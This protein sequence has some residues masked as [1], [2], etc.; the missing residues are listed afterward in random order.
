VNWPKRV[1]HRKKVLATIYRKSRSYPFYR[2]V[3]HVDGARRMKAFANYSGE[4]GAKQWADELVKGLFKG[5]KVAALTPRQAS[6]ALTAF[7]RLQRHFLATGKRV[8]LLASVSEYCEESAKANGY[9]LGAMVDGFLSTVAAVN[10][11]DIEK[12]AEQF[13]E[14][15]KRRTVTKDGRRPQLSPEHHYNTSLWL[16]E[17]GKAF[18]GHAVCDL[19]KDFLNK[20]IATHADAAPKTRNER[21][22]MVKMFLKWCVEKDYLSRTHRL[23]EASDLKH[24]IADPEEIECYTAAE[25]RKMLERA[26]KPPGPPKKG[27][28]PERDFQDLTP[29][30]AL[31]GL[32]GIREK[33]IMRLTFEDLFRVPDHVEVKAFK[34][35]TRSRRL[36]QSCAALVAW[37]EPYRGQTGPV[38]PKGYDMFHEDFA[39]L[40][41]ELK[42][43]ARRNGLRHSFVSAHFAAYSDEGLTAAQ[44][45]NSPAMVHKNY[46]GL[47]TKKEGEAWFAVKP[48]T[49]AQ[50][51]IRLKITADQN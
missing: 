24:E 34:A 27:Q 17:F 40:R 45:G 14:E 19:T 33:E 25:L 31:A 29:F 46:K 42:I 26:S 32:A 11:M 47:I 7:E 41:S 37:L 18:P 50:N 23:F 2:V 28:E 38:W 39:D 4:K 44:A 3:Y 36:V 1:E 48:A 43:P 6:D 20:Y 51:V 21:R 15:R 16:R 30:I 10:R 12:A 5:S 35:K 9:T 8:S 13:I 49:A 22:G